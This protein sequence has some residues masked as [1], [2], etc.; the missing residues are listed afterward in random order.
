M[1]QHQSTR[2]RNQLLRKVKIV[3]LQKRVKAAREKELQT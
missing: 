3:L 1:L 2:K